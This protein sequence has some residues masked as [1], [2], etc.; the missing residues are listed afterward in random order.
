MLIGTGLVTVFNLLLVLAHFYPELVAYRFLVGI[1]SAMWNISRMAYIAEVVPTSDRGRVLS[2]FGGV[3]RIGVFV[4]PAAGGL[5]AG[6]F[7]LAAPFLVT[8]AMAFLALTI[9]GLFVHE[10]SS[11]VTRHG[12]MRWLT[13]GGV[14]RRYYRDFA[15]AGGAQ[16]FAQM[17]RAGRQLII[18]LYGSSALGM[19]VTSVGTIVTT[20]AAIDMSLFLP[21]GMIMDRL[22]R[23]FASV[24]PFAIL[25]V[26]MALIPLSRGYTGLLLAACVM[27]LGNG[28]GSGAMMT[29]GADLAPREATGEFLGV[30]RLIGDAGATGGPLIVGGIA[31]MFGLAISAFTLAGLG[32]FAALMLIFF[33]RETLTTTEMPESTPAPT[34]VT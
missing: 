31:D 1:G 25:G 18:P 6:Q 30:W 11:K 8:A 21:A 7:G 13:L 3:M 33:V 26:G 27:A 12:R 28:L 9:A 17:I 32:W 29:L 24:P 15:S 23:K 10:S 4:G 2:S 20:A 34:Q 14:I 22:G 16:V 5:I 19:D